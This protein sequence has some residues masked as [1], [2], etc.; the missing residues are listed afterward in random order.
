MQVFESSDVSFPGGFS[1][2]MSVYVRDDAELL[3]RALESI[4]LNS[5]SPNQIVLVADGPLSQDLENIILD[6]SIHCTCKFDFYKIKNYLKNDYCY[7]I[8]TIFKALFQSSYLTKNNE[9]ALFYIK[10]LMK[11]PSTINNINLIYRLLSDVKDTN[12]TGGEGSFLSRAKRLLSFSNAKSSTLSYQEMSPDIVNK[13]NPLK[14]F[15]IIF[16]FI[17]NITKL[18]L[19]IELINENI[20]KIKEN[21]NYKI[22]FYDINDNIIENQPLINNKLKEIFPLL[23]SIINDSEKIDDTFN[24]LTFDDNKL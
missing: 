12:K 20:E 22:E 8:K 11:K 17:A 4:H 5:L 3:R 19:N 16:D 13:I 18:K 7:D 2:L 10:K 21:D 23:L 15:N 6:F 9:Y 24:R 1:V 14:L